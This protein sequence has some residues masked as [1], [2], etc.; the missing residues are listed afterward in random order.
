MLINKKH[1]IQIIDKSEK[2][3]RRCCRFILNDYREDN[4]LSL[5]SFQPMLADCL[6]DLMQYYQSLCQY[7]KKLVLKKSYYNYQW[8]SQRMNSLKKYKE[9]IND[10]IDVGKEIG[11]NFVWV[12]FRNNFEELDKHLDHKPTGIFPAGIG[13]LG[14]IAFIKGNPSLFECYVIYHGITTMLRIGDFSLY[15]PEHGIIAVGELKT[16]KQNQDLA[17]KAVLRS[18]VYLGEDIKSSKD[19]HIPNEDKLSKQI[20]NMEKL[21]AKTMFDRKTNSE[22]SFLYGMI[23]IAKKNKPKTSVDL[24]NRFAVISCKHSYGSLSKITMHN[25]PDVTKG[26]DSYKDDVSAIFTPKR[27][28]NRIMM[29]STDHKMVMGR[30]PTLLWNISNELKEKL[31]FREIFA[32]TVFNPVEIYEYFISMGFTV[33]E[34]NEFYANPTFEKNTDK[35]RITIG[36]LG[37]IFDMI[38]NNFLSFH[39]ALGIF[40]NVLSSNLDFDQNT[41]IILKQFLRT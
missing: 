1:T 17:I 15:S 41:K 2:V 3:L 14:E 35:G 7:E 27:P 5:W 13:G 10:T 25:L 34:S 12:F 24:Y 36:N 39:S 22:S 28:Y 37:P 21:I 6:Y 31:L 20:K 29:G 4:D 11:D 19:F 18:K 23:Q 40:D 9:A 16:E 38:L 26:S 8:F 30:L 32:Y 33:V